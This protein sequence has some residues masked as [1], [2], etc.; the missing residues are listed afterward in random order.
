LAADGRTG[1]ATSNLQADPVPEFDTIVLAGGGAA[2]MDGADKPALMVGGTPMLVSVAK[3]AV[4][5]GTRAIVIVGPPRPGPVQD[6]LELVTGDLPGGLAVVSEDPAGGGPVAALRRGLTE[7]SAPVLLLLG[8]DLPFLTKA[9]LAALLAAARPETAAISG[10][11]L[12]DDGGQPQWLT[13]CWRTAVVR[14]ALADYR[15][16]SLRGLLGPLQPVLARAP[17]PP[18]AAP[19]WLDCDTPEELAQ[20]RNLARPDSAR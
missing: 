14:A 11:L 5:A 17:L 2:R 13:S 16:S 18:G 9:P 6:E 19:P 1:A 20:A 8:A 10:A 7:V 12:A 15:G 3:A 4:S